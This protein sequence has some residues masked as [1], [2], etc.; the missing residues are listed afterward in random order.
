MAYRGQ[1]PVV[2]N[3]NAIDRSIA[4]G[5]AGKALHALMDKYRALEVLDG[6]LIALFQ[7]AMCGWLLE[8]GSE[9]AY[10]AGSTLPVSLSAPADASR[11]RALRVL[12]MV[13]ELHKVGY[14]RLR[15][16]AGMSPSGTHWRCSIT[17][18][19]NVHVNG[20]EP[21]DWDRNVAHYSTADG[22]RYFGWQDAARKSARQLAQMFIERFP[23]LA[24]SS[25]GR[26]RA[27]AGWF[28]GTLGAAENGRLPIIFADGN[29]QLSESELPPPPCIRFRESTPEDAS[30]S[31]DGRS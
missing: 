30:R 23:H 13:A 29:V 17:P 6:K 21:V 22:S 12:T 8:A 7:R 14:Q 27:Y 28:V 20:W 4:S 11:R 15:I 3:V 2:V 1:G 10:E 5:D 26:D 18:M 19:D 9:E 25:A 16:A 31:R 24:A